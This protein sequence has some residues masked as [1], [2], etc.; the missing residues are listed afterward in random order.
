ML[1]WLST[2]S[3]RR[4]ILHS[5]TLILLAIVLTTGYR[6][7]ALEQLERV[8]AE[9]MKLHDD[10]ITLQN[11]RYHTTQIQQYLTDA[12]LTGDADAISEAKQ[13]QASTLPLLDELSK[14]D[15]GNRSPAP[16]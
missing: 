11:L 1:S 16:A 13:H 15:L 2:F 8:V 6:L 10:A 7:F 4:F 3:T 5:S 12:S 14:L 9:E